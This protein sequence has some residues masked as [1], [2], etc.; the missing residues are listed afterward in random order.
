MASFS[1]H[2]AIGKRYIEKNPGTIQD[3]HEFYKGI[4]MPDLVEDKF[5][6]HY[7]ISPEDATLPSRLENKVH[8]E[9]F[10]ENEPIDTDCQKGVFLH[11]ITDYLF[12]NT[13]FD[14]QYVNTT[15]YDDFCKA[16]YYS[17]NCMDEYINTKYQVDY[18]DF[19]DI[20][21]EDIEKN[22]KK[23]NLTYESGTN[24]L[25][26]DLLDKFIEEVSNIN[27]EEYSE[28]IKKAHKNVLPTLKV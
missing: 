14:K 16:L 26:S 2:L 11:L 4:I 21:K 15:S 3:I 23:R 22:N 7:T 9:A 20:I 13:L 28:D 17:Y 6:S 24:L 1:I 18:S 25:P 27:L 8:L 5:I 10:L 19:I 12:F